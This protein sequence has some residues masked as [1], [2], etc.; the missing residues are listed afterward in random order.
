MRLVELAFGMSF[1]TVY[2][3]EI[4]TATIPL[5]SASRSLRSLRFLS[6]LSNAWFS[7]GS[8][9]PFPRIFL[10]N[11]ADILEGP[12]FLT[13]FGS[14]SKSKMRFDRYRACPEIS[15]FSCRFV[16]VR[17][18]DLRNELDSL[19]FQKSEEVFSATR[20]IQ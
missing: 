5:G 1:E 15:P 10:S 2:G 14:S 6:F 4:E 16:R 3:A 19:A 20:R 11:P 12:C 18:V 13:V 7:H 17:L 9:D 8:F